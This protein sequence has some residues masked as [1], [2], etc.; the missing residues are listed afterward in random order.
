MHIPDWLRFE[1]FWNPLLA[2]GIAIGVVVIA[3]FLLGLARR[4]VR[5]RLQVMAGRHELAALKIAAHAAGQ[6]RGWFLFLVAIF[7]GTRLLRLPDSFHSSLV[8]AATIGLLVQM[9]LWATAAFTI[10][11]QLRRERQLAIDPSTVAAMD[12]LGFVLRVA[13]WTLVLLLTLDNIGIDITALIAGL[14]IGG[15]A[16]ALA[17][18]NILGDLFASLSIMLD[19]PFVVGDFLTVNEYAGSVEKIGIKTTRLRSLSGEQLVFSNNDLLNS[20]IRNYGR[21]FERRVVFS[22]GITYETPV[23]KLKL[24][25]GILREAIESQEKVRF[26]R[27]HFQKYGDFALHFEIVYYVTSSDYNLYMDIQQT[28]N[29]IIYERFADEGIEFAYPTQKLYVARGEEP[30]GRGGTS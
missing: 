30:A 29:L 18:Q 22:L 14:G 15:I 28:I 4:V 7:L 3:W 2:W 20:R 21:M 10:G 17:T 24:I 6:T 12:V 13:I 27:A 23:E 11:M 26:D 25:P 8:N 9:G 16:V 5:A 1:V 19:Q